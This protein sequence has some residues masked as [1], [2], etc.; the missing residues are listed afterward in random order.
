MNVTTFFLC[1]D[2]TKQ[3]QLDWTKRYNI[4]RGITRG[5]L[6]L[7]QDSRLTIIHR[8]L[9]ASNILLDADMNPKIADFGMARIF[10]I[11]QSG[12][13]TKKIAG[14][15]YM[16]SLPISNLFSVS[17]VHNLEACEFYS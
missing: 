9:K 10:G 1:A 2:P 12:A 17:N 11:D 14:T 13:N 4:I 3:G 16:P 6:Y 15:R 7:H 5:I 8:D